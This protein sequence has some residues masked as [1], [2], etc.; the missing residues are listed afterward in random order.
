M[1]QLLGGAAIKSTLF[2]VR[3]QHGTIRFLGSGSGH[4]VG[5]SQWGALALARDG[6]SWQEILAH[7]Y[8]GSEILRASG[9]GWGRPASRDGL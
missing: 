7:Y 2:D 6:S 9:E 5:L 1:R 4:G 8:P 3:E